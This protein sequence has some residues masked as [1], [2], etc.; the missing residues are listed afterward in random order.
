[1]NQMNHCKHVTCVHKAN[2]MKLADGLF[3]ETCRQVAKEYEC[4][5]INF[6]DMIVNNASMQFVAKPQQ[7]DV[8]VWSYCRQ[9]WC[10]SCPMTRD[11]SG[12]KQRREFALFEPGCWH[13]AKD[14]M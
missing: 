5:G 7:F 14:I 1:M 4:S 2:I 3:L 9:H 6:S 12:G 10:G 8:M 11:C 13:V